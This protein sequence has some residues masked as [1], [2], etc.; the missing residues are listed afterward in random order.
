MRVLTCRTAP[1]IAMALAGAALLGGCATQ[2]DRVILLPDSAGKPSGAVA[3]RT[4]KDEVL[5]KE[6][7]A[8]ARVVGDKIETGRSSAEQVKADFAP[9]LA[10]LPV[11]AQ[12]WVIYFVEGT[13][14]LTPESLP[15]LEVL[16]TSLAAIPAGEVIVTGHT[17]R[18]G[19][20]AD[21]DRLSVGRAEA[22]RELLVAAG[23]ARERITVGGR[24]EREPVVPTADEVDEPRNRRV[25]IKLR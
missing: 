10:L 20:V 12:Q 6:A 15:L 18:V 23:V 17:D 5:L 3:V 21:N 11:R 7:Y 9:L 8:E 4:P 2:F 14:T 19:S 13:E 24:G 1:R 25:E 16:K 22:V